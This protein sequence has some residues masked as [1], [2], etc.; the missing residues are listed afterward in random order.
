MRSRKKKKG[1][2]HN[3]A[4]CCHL[5]A[6]YL[7]QGGALLGTLLSKPLASASMGPLGQHRIFPKAK[8]PPSNSPVTLTMSSGFPSMTGITTVVINA[9][10]GACMPAK[11]PDS[12]QP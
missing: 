6:A 4:P 12:L 3:Q 10:L 9:A 1:S 2:K 7:T 8:M 11:S 5:V